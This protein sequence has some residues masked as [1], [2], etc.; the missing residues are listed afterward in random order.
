MCVFQQSYN[1]GWS[2]AILFT[3]GASPPRTSLLATAVAMRPLRCCIYWF[4]ANVLAASVWLFVWEHLK[5]VELRANAASRFR[6]RVI[7]QHGGA[8]EGTAWR[9]NSSDLGG[10]QVPIASTRRPLLV[11]FN[12]YSS[13]QTP[14]H[15]G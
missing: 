15:V 1:D 12:W 4:S 6:C 10:F 14:V 9:E 7:G 8:E 5:L 11:R 2:C 13:Q 3:L